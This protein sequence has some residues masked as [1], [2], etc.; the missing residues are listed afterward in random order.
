VT[1]P[2]RP[3]AGVSPQ[4]PAPVPGR[5]AYALEV[6]RSL[7]P[8]PLQVGA[9]GS[10]TAPEQARFLL[11]PTPATA[12]LLVPAGHRRGAGRAVH[13]QL[14]GRRPRTRAARLLL[15]AAV[16]S[17]LADR[18][19]SGP[20]VVSGPQDA[21]S[22]ERVLAGVLQ[23]DRLLVSLPLSLPRAN[24]KPVLQVCDPQGRALAFVKVGHD[25]LTREL[26]AAEGE[27]LE[28]LARAGLEGVHV[29]GV[30][31]R[32]TWNGLDLLVLEPLP[33]AQRRL[34]GPPARAAF[35]RV[36]SAIAAL[37]AAPAAPWAGSAFRARLSAQLQ[38]CGDQA[39]ALLAHLSALDP[40]APQL[41]LGSWHGDLNPG[42]I[43]LLPQRSLV[44]D[45]ERFE[46]GVP[47]GFDVLH[48]DLH[49][50]VT[51]AQVP[52]AQAARQL[53][54]TAAPALAPLGLGPQEAEATARLYLLT[55]AARYLRDQQ[56]EAGG[57]LGPV[58]VWLL[59]AL[60]ATRRPAP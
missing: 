45:W 60:D 20:L 36:A 38:A 29:P 53:L 50:D 19:A 22:V 47:L 5:A 44:W 25:A 56:S 7:Y 35:L 6:L 4:A 34:T 54:D 41:A 59:P 55:L 27:S 9:P 11:L 24:R 12:R 28:R 31:A 17:G 51:M 52:P 30:L 58:D 8:P 49:R 3:G 46:Q 40:A 23:R 43:A 48:H 57:G 15:T 13:R 33:L 21:D 2:A 10:G 37:D 39:D 14:V 32:L 42:N 18:L 16:G 1:G 26:V